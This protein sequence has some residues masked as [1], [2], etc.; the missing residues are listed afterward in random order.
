MAFRDARRR[1]QPMLLAMSCVVLGVAAIVASFSFRDNLQTSIRARAKSLLGADLVI[2]GR[3]PFS[4]EEENLLKSIGGEQSRQIAF[5]SMAF[6]PESG[7][8]RLVEVRAIR[9]NFPY[10][11]ALETDP[12]SARQGFQSGAN[13]LVDET[14]MLQFNAGIGDRLRI[15]EQDFRIAGKL[16]RIPGESLA[17]SLLNPRVYVPLAHFDQAQLIQKGSLVRYRVFFKLPAEV[18]P[19]KIAQRLAPELTRLRLETDTVSRRMA[20]IS[21]FTDNLSRYLQ[22]A[23]FIAV[24]LAGVGVASA[25]HVY[26]KEKTASVAVLRCIGASPME[27]VHVYLIQAVLIALA[28]SVLGAILGVGLQ[29]LLPIVLED[30]LPVDAVIS[31]SISGILAGVGTG[32]GTTLLFALIPIVSLRQISPLFALRASYESGGRSR[33]PILWTIFLLIVLAILA[34]ALATTGQW[35]HGFSFTAALLAAFG[36][37]TFISRTVA[38]LL[39]KFMPDFLPFPWRQGLAS[40]HRPN[41]QTTAVMLS[42]GLGAFLLITLYS[43][44][45]MLVSQVAERGG[46]GDANLVLFDVQ[47]D[48]RKDVGALLQSFKVGA[49]EEVPIVTMRLAA[50]KGR[51]V[52]EIRADTSSKI[53]GWALRREYR[54][55]YRSQLA[56]TEKIIDGNWHGKVSPDTQPI[57]ISLEKGIAESLGVSLGDELEFELQGVSLPTRVASIRDVDWQRIQPNFFAVFPE[58]V[59][60]SAP[61]F[62]AVVSRADSS[63]LSAKLQRAV[64]ERFPNVSMIDLTLVLNTLDSILGRVSSAIRFVA[65]FTILTGLAVLIS[66]V[67]SSRTQRLKESIL[68]KTLGAPRHQIITA[69]VAEYLFLGAIS[70]ATAALLATMASW[71]L[72]FYFLG[73]VASISWLPILA[74]VAIVT[75]ATVLA[76][77]IGCWGMFRRSALEALRV[78]A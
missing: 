21:R 34:F 48:Q 77:I 27:T 5:S 61:Q 7:R 58:G 8:S 24:L 70:C 65:L 67:L 53:P 50:I 59:L 69:I 42:I 68:M 29:A 72:S 51:S 74:I 23:V 28:G 60:E 9:G 47:K 54:S 75:G 18:D 64:V 55:T 16:L 4:A 17:F 12:M 49:Y 25:I 71:G 63:Q 36:L 45:N 39:K 13:A 40:L 56:G 6:F 35:L 26:V 19:D 52:E 66:A 38:M 14:V 30:F 2:Q 43:A 62:Y 78:E 33:D 46:R 41:N 1:I 31:Y 20:T 37:L 10:Y 3:E 15:G 73:T 22:L 44:R 11:G 32:L 76:G 57:P